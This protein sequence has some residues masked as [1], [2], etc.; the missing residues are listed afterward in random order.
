MIIDGIPL[1]VA[2]TNCWIVS[3]NHKEC[4][5]IDVPPDPQAVLG[6]L[7]HWNLKP[8]AIIATHGHADHVGGVSELLKMSVDH[9]TIDDQPVTP[10]TYIHPQDRHM[11]DDPISSSYMLIPA[12]EATG[13]D[14]RPPEEIIDLQDGDSV[15]GAGMSFV[16]LHTPGHTQ[17]SV[18]IQLSVE[19]Q[20]PMLFS[21]D[22]LF[23]GS[24]GRTDL[25]GGSYT[26]LMES[27][28]TKIIPLADETVVLPGH[29][30]PTTIGR[31]KKMNQF[32]QAIL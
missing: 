4:V 24:I 5:L 31:E 16:A 9:P 1:W 10:R 23:R 25:P 22:H 26:Q 29:G 27:M 18:C 8:V 17:G 15:K 28:S 30:D 6:R 21:G 19:N 13:F 2:S 11:I 32:L 14:F 12:L 20:P 7:E 3:V